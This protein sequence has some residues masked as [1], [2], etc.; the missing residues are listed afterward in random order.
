LDATRAGLTIALQEHSDMAMILE[1][2]NL[3]CPGESDRVRGSHMKDLAFQ[4]SSGHEKLKQGAPHPRCFRTIYCLSTN[5]SLGELT[6]G[7]SQ[8][9]RLA[10]AD[11]LISLPVPDD[12][13]VFE[14]CPAEYAG[15]GEFAAALLAC[16]QQQHGTAIRLFLQRLVQQRAEDEKVLRERLGH[17]LQRFRRAAGVSDNDGSQSRVADG[18]GLVMAAGR[19]AKHYGVLPK[20]LDCDAV[21]LACYRLCRPNQQPAASVIEQL[22]AISRDQKTTTIDPSRLPTLTNRQLDQNGV[23]LHRNRRRQFELLFWPPAFQKRFPSFASVLRQPEVCAM[24]TVD[25]DRP[26]VK[27]VIR[28]GR[29]DRVYCFVLPS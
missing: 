17:H 4:L 22:V 26:T 28:Q 8:A 5:Q 13:G 23:F 27:R 12:V 9:S 14:S 7:Q 20:Q 10:A 6:L 21:A 15:R 2:A 1:E 3:F 18:F 16:A 24:L 11:R 29:E 19:L 25:K